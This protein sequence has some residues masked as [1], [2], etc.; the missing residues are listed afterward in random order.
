MTTSLPFFLIWHI[1]HNIFKTCFVS[2]CTRRFKIRSS[3]I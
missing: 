3:V 1:R 2:I